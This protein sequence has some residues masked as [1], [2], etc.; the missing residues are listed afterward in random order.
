METV[1]VV[2]VFSVRGRIVWNPYFNVNSNCSTGSSAL[3]LAAQAV[4]GGQV[5]CALVVGFEQMEPGAL[6]SKCKDRVNPLER[7]V[8]TMINGNGQIPLAA[9]MFGGAGKEYQERYGTKADT[10]GKIAVKA[11]RTL[12]TIHMPYSAIPYP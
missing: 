3:M 6:G 1:P 2:T 11:R 12:K 9:Q 10:F 5:Q 8:Q 4:A 7:H